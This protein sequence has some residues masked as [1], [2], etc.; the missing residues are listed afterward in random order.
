MKDSN[1]RNTEDL[2]DFL[3][4]MKEG[5]PEDKRNKKGKTFKPW[6]KNSFYE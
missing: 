2:K 6:Q 1:N 4:N 3:E 5:K